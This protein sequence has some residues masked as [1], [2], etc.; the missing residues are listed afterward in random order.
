MLWANEKRCEEKIQQTLIFVTNIL[1]NDA[2]GHDSYH[3]EHVHKLTTIICEKEGDD[4]FIEK[5]K[6]QN[7][8]RSF[9]ASDSMRMIFAPLISNFICDNDFILTLPLQLSA[10][11]TYVQK[12]CY[13]QV[14]KKNIFL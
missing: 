9:D 2:S 4:L 11:I 1:E 13:I 12:L 5:I 14:N 6:D 8:S 10:N 7:F 3:I